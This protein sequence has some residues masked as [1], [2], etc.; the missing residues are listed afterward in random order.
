[1]HAFVFC[2]TVLSA[3]GLMRCWLL[4]LKMLL[5]WLLLLSSLF[6]LVMCLWGCFCC[7]CW[8]TIWVVVVVVVGVFAARLVRE[9]ATR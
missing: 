8:R 7:S 4:F 5:L 6:L 2:V 9:A 1:M 3:A